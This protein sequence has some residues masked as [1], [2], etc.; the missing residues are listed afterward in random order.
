M[1]P[2]QIQS[3]QKDARHISVNN[4]LKIS[5]DVNPVLKRRPAMAPGF[6]AARLPG[7]NELNPST[8]TYMGSNHN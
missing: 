1:S 7:R 3:I 8:T 2:N 4:H 6:S 5:T